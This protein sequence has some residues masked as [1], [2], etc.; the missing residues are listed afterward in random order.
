VIA[1]CRFLLLHTHAA[2]RKTLQSIINQPKLLE[3]STCHRS[4]LRLRP[5]RP[6][7]QR[8]SA[9]GQR[10][11][12]RLDRAAR[13]RVPRDGDDR[14]AALDAILGFG[15]DVLELPAPCAPC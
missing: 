4:P 14:H 10:S 7:Q 15:V 3:L 5:W 12:A 2:D 6:R 8:T 13:P 11:E 9:I 1:T